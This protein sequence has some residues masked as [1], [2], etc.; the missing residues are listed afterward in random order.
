MVAKLTEL[1]LM[2]LGTV[3]GKVLA[4]HQVF[5]GRKVLG[6]C[7]SKVANTAADKGS[8]FHGIRRLLDSEDSYYLNQSP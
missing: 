3:Q 4:A 1:S 5:A 8:P 2:E 7:K 6:Q